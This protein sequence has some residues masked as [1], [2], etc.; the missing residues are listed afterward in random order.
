MVPLSNM[1]SHYMNQEQCAS[2]DRNESLRSL[3]PA[4]EFDV[5]MQ[6]MNSTIKSDLTCSSICAWSPRSSVPRHECT[7]TD[8]G[9]DETS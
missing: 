2:M 9:S 3:N 4:K 7:T 1:Q 6:V 8:S 5:D